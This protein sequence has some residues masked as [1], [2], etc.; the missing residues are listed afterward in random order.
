MILILIF[1]VS[2]NKTS[3]LIEGFWAVDKIKYKGEDLSYLFMVN[4]IFFDENKCTLPIIQEYYGNIRKEE[5]EWKIIKEGREIYIVIKTENEFFAGKHEVCFEKD[6]KNKVIK[7]IVKS[8]NL[9]FEAT[10]GLFN[11]DKNNYL[12]DKYLCKD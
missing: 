10:K 7:M 12:F 9:Y 4:L 11:F 5:G 2:C 6:Y 1:Y 8:K 3:Q